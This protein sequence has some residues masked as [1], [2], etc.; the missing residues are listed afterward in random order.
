MKAASSPAHGVMPRA[1]SR[2][3]AATTLA[4]LLADEALREL[5]LGCLGLAY[6]D[7]RGAVALGQAGL[8]GRAPQAIAVLRRHW[9]S[10]A[11]PGAAPAP[12]PDQTMEQLKQALCELSLSQKGTKPVLLARLPHGVPPSVYRAFRDSAAKARLAAALKVAAAAREDNDVLFCK[13]GRINASGARAA[14]FFLSGALLAVLP[15]RRVPKKK[16]VWYRTKAVAAVALELHTDAA[17]LAAIAAAAETARVELQ[18]AAAAMAAMKEVYAN[19]GVPPPP[20]QTRAEQLRRR[21]YHAAAAYLLRGGRP[22]GPTAQQLGDAVRAAAAAEEQLGRYREVW[23]PPAPPRAPAQQQR[24]CPHKRCAGSNRTFGEWG[25]AQHW[26]DLHVAQ[27]G[28]PPAPP[29][30]AA[31]SGAA[32]QAAAQ[33]LAAP[34]AQQADPMDGGAAAPPPEQPAPPSAVE[35]PAPTDEAAAAAAPTAPAPPPP[36]PPGWVGPRPDPSEW[37]L[38][39]KAACGRLVI[40]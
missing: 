37:C 10:L 35:Q 7:V 30:G 33:A 34:P 1:N 23:P 20:K 28:A 27:H 4:D 25:L 19:A 38:V 6:K 9:A 21:G 14:P 39:R 18:A 13:A 36:P 24:R 3:L 31:H 11:T 26:T 15:H 29:S 8:L 40:V 16:G 22:P 32:L 17:N 5:I 12:S 2:K